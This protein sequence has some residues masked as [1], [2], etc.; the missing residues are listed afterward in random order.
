M[1]ASPPAPTDRLALGIALVASLLVALLTAASLAHIWRQIPNA[2]L[3]STLLLGLALALLG[4]RH[5]DDLHRLV[6]THRHAQHRAHLMAQTDPL[7]GCLNRQAM[8]LHTDH[9]I[10]TTLAAGDSLAL[11]MVDI[12]NF[13][14]LNADDGHDTGDAI[15]TTWA[16][17]IGGLL[18]PGA[19]LAR[20]GGDEFACAIPFARDDHTAI[21]RLA[22]QITAALPP[23]AAASL[24]ATIG[25][26][27]TATALDSAT[28]LHR[29]DIA[30]YQAKKQGPARTLWFTPSMQTTLRYRCEMETALR[31]AIPR[32]ECL[33]TY[34]QQIDLATGAPRGYALLPRW[35][36][37]EFGTVGP[38]VLLPLAEDI[39]LIA[40][41]SESLIAQALRDAQNWDAGLTLTLP[42][43]PLLLRDPWFAQKLL[44]LL[45]EAHFPPQ[46]LEIAITEACLHHNLA[47]VQAL[48][49]SLRNQ[50]ITIALDGLGTGPSGLAQLRK[51]PFDRL[52]IAPSLLATMA[53]DPDSRLLVDAITTLGQGLG[54]PITTT[55]TT[56]SEI[57]PAQAPAPPHRRSA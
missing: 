34:T 54:L 7:T 26:A 12:N 57:Q 6:L 52:T 24:T 31:A 23:S 49:T 40:P 15:L 19:L 36:S 56:P 25:I 51:L 18:P 14:Q 17:H 10:T 37:P 38:E 9:L 16:I 41:L 21:D 8:A 20:L 48:I 22:A 53:H 39:G 28:L 46:R 29:A 42:L 47:I 3:A 27:H 11:L 1:S 5:Y 55:D 2:P 4:W 45:V 43:S 44:K 33:P 32:G 13:K 35:H 30:L 50:G